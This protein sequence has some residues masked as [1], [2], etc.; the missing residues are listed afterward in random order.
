ML[1]V[2]RM[3]VRTKGPSI[4]VCEP[5][6]DNRLIEPRAGPANDNAEVRRKQ[7]L[8][9]L[10]CFY[11]KEGGITNCILGHY[12]VHENGSGPDLRI[13]RRGRAWSG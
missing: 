2:D 4:R 7:R 5:G 6:L 3:S 11:E 9:G 12:G 8:G 10:L 13:P 1:F